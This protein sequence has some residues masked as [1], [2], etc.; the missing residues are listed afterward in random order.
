M[1]VFL[2]DGKHFLYHRHSSN[3]ENSGTFIGSLD[4]KPDAPASARLLAEAVNPIYA[5]ASDGRSGYILFRR[6]RALMAQRFDESKLA[7]SGDPVL[8][9]DYVGNMSASFLNAAVSGRTLIIREAGIADVRQ[10]VWMDR[11]GVKAQVPVTEPGSWSGVTLSVDGALAAAHRSDD[12]GNFDVYTIDLTRRLPTRLTFDR[13]LDGQPIWSPDRSRIVFVSDRGG[14]R[15]LFWKAANGTTQEELLYN[16]SNQNL[17]EDWSRDGKYILFTSIGGK[18]KSDIWTLFMAGPE[19]KATLFLGT[20]ANEDQAR[21]SPDGRYVIYRSDEGGTQQIYMRT[22]P[23]TGGKW[24]ISKDGAANPRWSHDG[25][26]IY[27]TS[28]GANMMAVKISTT[29]TVQLSDPVKLFTGFDGGSYDVAADGRFL[30]A[31][32]TGQNSVNPITVTLH[33]QDALKK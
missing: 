1:P 4:D 10:L 23:D 20:D 12:Q 2:A 5:P 7:L 11:N 29:P 21:F 19:H 33:W 30:M 8:V 17:P 27:F 25:K 16:S 22:F 31:V 13:A 26:E 28:G 3:P 15:N 24:Q 32:T 6:E 14:G 9:A 18:S